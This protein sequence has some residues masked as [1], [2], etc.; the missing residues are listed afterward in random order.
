MAQNSPAQLRCICKLLRLVLMFKCKR[1]LIVN[2]FLH[3][4]RFLNSFNL[5]NCAA[6]QTKQYNFTL[7]TVTE[8]TSLICVRPVFWPQRWVTTAWPVGGDEWPTYGEL[9]WCIS[10]NTELNCIPNS[11]LK[12]LVC[13]YHNTANCLHR[14]DK[15][16]MGFSSR[17]PTLKQRWTFSRR[18]L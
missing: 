18:N 8:N 7:F 14:K 6:R 1:T 11:L 10:H 16:V 3:L 9:P 4:L 13:C 5:M 15:G 17:G 2:I 12:D